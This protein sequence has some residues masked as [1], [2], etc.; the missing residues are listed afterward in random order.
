MD[1]VDPVDPMDPVDLVDT[2][3]PLDAMDLMDL[4]KWLD[5]DLDKKMH[6]S[7]NLGPFLNT[8]WENI[9]N[10]ISSVPQQEPPTFHPQTHIASSGSLICA[11][12]LET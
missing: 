7:I 3:D 12:V 5:P 2:M 1:P 10:Q 6:Q 8:F 11:T 4:S 9:R